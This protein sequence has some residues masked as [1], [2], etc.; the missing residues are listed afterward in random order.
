M[1]NREPPLRLVS[2]F[3]ESHGSPS[4]AVRLA[5]PIWGGGC[6]RAEMLVR[7]AQL[8]VL[9]ERETEGSAYVP[10]LEEVCAA[11]PRVHELI[12]DVYDG[13]EVLTQQP[14]ADPMVLLDSSGL[15][16]LCPLVAHFL[17]DPDKVRAPRATPPA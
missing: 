17:G 3:M 9:L 4:V 16:G 5:E 11:R 14:G 7:C 12:Q 13:A 8:Q 1:L 6:T 15:S 2:S 10:T